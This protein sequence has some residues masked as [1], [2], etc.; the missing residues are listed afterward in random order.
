MRVLAVP[1]RMSNRIVVWYKVLTSIHGC[2]ARTQLGLLLSAVLDTL[3]FLVNPSL[4]LS[5]K[6]YIS[7]IVCFKFQRSYVYFYVRGFSDDLYNVMPGREGDVNELILSSLKEDDVFLDVGANIGYY[8]VLAGK[9]IG[10][11]GRVISVEPVP[12]TAEVLNYNIKLNN[13]RNVKVIQKAT[14]SNNQVITMYVP[15]SFFGMASI[16]NLHDADA[17]DVEGITLDTVCE[18]PEVNLLKIDAEGSEYQILEGARKT[19]EKT[20]NVIL[21]ASSEKDKIIGLLREEQFK[22]RKLRFTSHVLAYK[23]L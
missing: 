4:A 8:S 22:I 16:C 11:S 21:E 23:K 7:G 14:W 10:D 15:E 18:A 2:D 19:L 3:S 6:I 1:I 20:R 5:P 17:L 12:S 13:L 9:I